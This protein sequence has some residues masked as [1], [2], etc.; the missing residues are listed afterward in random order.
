[1]DQSLLNKISQESIDIINAKYS[2]FHKKFVMFD[3]YNFSLNVTEVMILWRPGHFQ[4]EHIY[5][6][7]TQVLSSITISWERLWLQ[8]TLAT[9]DPGKFITAILL[10]YQ[11][12][13]VKKKFWIEK[14]LIKEI[15][16]IILFK[17]I[18]LKTF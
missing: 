8:W 11:Y 9:M 12:Y 3:E 15:V 5:N 13:L 16:K 4:Y 1:M 7:C 18:S 10:V 2:K 14:Y 17:K 6:S